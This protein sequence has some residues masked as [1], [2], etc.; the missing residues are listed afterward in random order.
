MEEGNLRVLQQLEA[1]CNNGD[2][3]ATPCEEDDPTVHDF[4]FNLYTSVK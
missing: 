2:A 1:K 4:V 3:N